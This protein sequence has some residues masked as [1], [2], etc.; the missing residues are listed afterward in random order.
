MYN[1]RNGDIHIPGKSV[2][3]FVCRGVILSE[4]ARFF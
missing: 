2:R 1:I 3:C 4:F